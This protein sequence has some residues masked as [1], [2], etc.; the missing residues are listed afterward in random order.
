VR[1]R[2]CVCARA[3]LIC[4]RVLRRVRVPMGDN[5]K[6]V[7]AFVRACV[8]V[9]VR[10]CV[11]VCAGG[12]EP[13]RDR[14]RRAPAADHW[15]RR[16]PRAAPRG[17]GCRQRRAQGAVPRRARGRARQDGRR[18]AHPRRG[19]GRSQLRQGRRR[20][21][22]VGTCASVAPQEHRAPVGPAKIAGLARRRCCRRNP[23][24]WE[25]PVRVWFLQACLLSPRARTRTVIHNKFLIDVFVLLL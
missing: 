24:R 19:G 15:V 17:G 3:L 8:R 13:G 25:K 22:G 4:M 7:C 1:V 2:G 11:G 5:R 18:Q 16:G 9:R 6:C 20:A 21:V 10:V 12:L 14:S 23:G